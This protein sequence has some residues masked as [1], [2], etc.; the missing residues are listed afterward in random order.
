[1]TFGHKLILLVTLLLLSCSS[2]PEKRTIIPNPTKY[3]FSCSKDSV[4]QTII[5]ELYK[6]KVTMRLYFEGSEFPEE[7]AD[8]FSRP[9]NKEDF[10]L[11]DEL[12]WI[13]ESYVYPGLKYHASFHLHILEIDK[14]H[15]EVIVNTLNPRVI[16]G[17]E[18]LPSG[19]HFA[20]DYKYHDVEPSTIEEY[21]I[22]FKIGQA[23][24]QD[25]PKVLYPQ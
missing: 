1:M 7:V 13:N 10:Y 25:M 23:L 17:E 11:Y 8:I 19:P 4:R 9:E 16:I 12:P 21:E 2:L 15:T 14:G 18:L 22:L 24:N 20:K 6:Y 3:T 5:S